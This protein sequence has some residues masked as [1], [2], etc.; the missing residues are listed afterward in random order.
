MK[1]FPSSALVLSTLAVAVACSSSSS[2]SGNSNDGGTANNPFVNAPI[3]GANVTCKSDPGGGATPSQSDVA[4]GNCNIKNCLDTAQKAF[5]SDPKTYGGSCGDYFK[6]GCD[7]LASDTKCLTACFPKST[8]ACRADLQSYNAC[9]ENK[10]AAECGVDKDT[11]SDGGGSPWDWPDS[12]P[13][14]VTDCVALSACCQQLDA[15]SKS[16]CEVAANTNN[17]TACKYTLDSY[18]SNGLCK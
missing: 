12:G 16:S 15:G 1:A 14:T 18:K 3:G 6:C 2:S 13:P 5:G 17:P 9:L 4:C 11:N 10:C 8:E 7:C